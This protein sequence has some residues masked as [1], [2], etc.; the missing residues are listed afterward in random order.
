MRWVVPCGQSLPQVSD[1]FLLGAVWEGTPAVA[2]ARFEAASD[3][4]KRPCFL[5]QINF[6]LVALFALSM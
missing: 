1:P 5:L 4:L 6:F 2:A 3:L